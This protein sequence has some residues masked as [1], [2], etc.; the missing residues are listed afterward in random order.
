MPPFGIVPP[1][2]NF[3]KMPLD[4]TLLISESF[5]SLTHLIVFRVINATSF[6]E[7][8]NIDNLLAYSI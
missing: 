3:A 8:K 1:L 4:F 5:F 2:R 7:L 6:H